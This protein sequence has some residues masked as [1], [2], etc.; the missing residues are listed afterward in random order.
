M[1]PQHERFNERLEQAMKST[2]PDAQDGSHLLGEQR[3]G[4][5]EID[6]LVD[7][8]QRF[9]AT[10][11][12]RVDTDF[13]E[14]LERRVLRHALISRQKAV[15]GGALVQF[16]R[17]HKVLVVTMSL[18]ILLVLLGLGALA[19]AA[20]TTNPA[21]PLSII[22]QWEQPARTTMTATTPI[23]QAT[24][25]LQTARASLQLL[26]NLTTPA[27]NNDYVQTLS[28]FDEQLTRTI[29]AINVLPAGTHK[30]HLA[31]QLDLLK[32]DARQ[33]L[34]GL[35]H[36]LTSTASAATTTELGHLGEQIPQVSSATI[37]LPAHPKETATIRMTGSG[38]QPG[39]QLLVN[40]KLMSITGT[41]QNGQVVF[42]L[43]WK[44]EQHPHS[45]GILNPDGTVAQTSNVTVQTAPKSGNGNANGNGSGK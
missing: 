4:D 5:S 25:D 19:L 40:G 8:A 30:T 14:T 36:T 20:Q 38:I 35:L 27:Q 34:R 42:V 41:F 31:G 2:T 3:A 22:K 39:A 15:R 6:E 13:A 7:L 1:N 24:V 37:V 10:P 32:S 33:K 23:D 43:T 26:V 18:C 11:H 16:W 45:L 21:N 28:H 9:Q 44:S 17:F 12:L 29:N